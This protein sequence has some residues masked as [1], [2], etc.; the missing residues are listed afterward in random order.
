MNEGDDGLKHIGI[1]ED[2][3]LNGSHVTL[4]CLLAKAESVQ[5][6]KVLTQESFDF[7]IQL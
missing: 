2:A 6:L 1:A 3:N 4:G 7:R 5:G